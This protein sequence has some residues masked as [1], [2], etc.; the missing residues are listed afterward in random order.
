ML[1]F[2]PRGGIEPSREILPALKPYGKVSAQLLAA[3][4]IRSRQEADRFLNPCQDQLH[5]PFLIHHMSRAVKML[6]DARDKRIPTVIYGDYDVDGICAN[7]LLCLALRRFGVQAEPYAPLREEGYGLNEPAVRRLAGVYG[8]LVTADLGVTNDR[9][10]E[11]AKELGMGV[12]VTDHHQSGLKACPAD[13][14]LSPLMDG[15]PCPRLCGA[16]TAFKLAQALLGQWEAMEYI[17]LAALATVADIVPLQEENRVIVA[18]GLPMISARKRQ[19]FR[20]LLEVSGSG[21][22]ADSDTLGYQLGPRL[23]AAGRLGNALSGVRLM[24][25]ADGEEADEIAAELDRLNTHRKKLENEVLE[26]ALAQTQAHDFVECPMLLTRGEGWHMGV[27]GLAASRLCSRYGCPTGVFCQEGSL[28]HGSLRSVPGVNIHKCLQTCDELLLRYGGHE[29][30]AGCTLDAERY[31]EF[32]GRMQRAVQKTA[33]VKAFI[34]TQEYDTALALEEADEDVLREIDR[35]G[36]FGMGNP[37]PLF[38]AE[39]LQLERRR[40]CGRLGAH[41]QLTLR[42]EGRVMD[43]IAFGMGKEAAALPR[44]VDMVYRLNRNTFQGITTLQCD[45]KAFRPAWGADRRSVAEAPEQDFEMALVDALLEMLTMEENAGIKSRN[46]EKIMDMHMHAGQGLDCQN[47]SRGTLFVARTKPSAMRLLEILHPEDER[48]GRADGRG[49]DERDEGRPWLPAALVWYTAE[50]P[51]CFPTVLMLPILAAQAG[52]WRQVWLLDGELGPVEAAL[53]QQR[54]PRA[55]VRVYSR[56]EALI[57]LAASV[58]AGDEAYRLL[59]RQLRCNAF[60]ALAQAAAA[61]EMT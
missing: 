38:L 1:R 50:D 12:I 23:N 35:L 2:V 32:C 7:A 48:P 5:D 57:S 49:M 31:K 61:A 37:F 56:T 33:R 16:G 60:S 3:R 34:P 29:Q 53:W 40:A 47:P 41:L 15:Y 4:G 25:T 21:S 14:V 59:Y 17:D 22:D 55:Q 9:E 26:Q 18:L 28:L 20:A 27:V 44:Q 42:Q 30:A 10:V 58:D 52:C 54:L 24:M 8:L 43:G 11:L 39:G 45:V 51:L 46:A 19:G 13:A 36:P 6:K